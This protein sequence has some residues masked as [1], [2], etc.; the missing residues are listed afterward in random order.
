MVPNFLTIFRCTVFI[1]ATAVFE[2]LVVDL[3]NVLV[4]AVHLLPTG[5][6][7]IDYGVI[8]L[9]NGGLATKAEYSDT[10]FPAADLHPNYSHGIYFTS[11]T[12]FCDSV[13]E[14]SVK[15][16]A[17]PGYYGNT[18]EMKFCSGNGDRDLG[19]LVKFN[20]SVGFRLHIRASRDQN[21]METSIGVALQIYWMTW[22]KDRFSC[23]GV[24]C[25]TPKKLKYKGYVCT[26]SKWQCDISELHMCEEILPCDDEDV[27]QMHMA[28]IAL[29]YIA[30]GI[31]VIVVCVCCWFCV[32]TAVQDMGEQGHTLGMFNIGWVSN[33]LRQGG[34]GNLKPIT[35]TDLSKRNSVGRTSFQKNKFQEISQEI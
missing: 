27:G 25:S 26:Q 8:S 3:E 16:S 15:T 5:N 1:Y 35:R 34:P 20:N 13:K 33:T 14:V 21:M 23:E 29:K 31:G 18:T 32:R 22:S 24:L 17:E 6:S 12:D 19:F 4:D 30:L 28:M 9:F 10:W 2:V 7:S 11:T